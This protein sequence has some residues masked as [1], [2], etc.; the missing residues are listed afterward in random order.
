MIL[1]CIGF[2]VGFKPSDNDILEEVASL[3]ERL[4]Q[5]NDSIAFN[6]DEWKRLEDNQKDLEKGNAELRKEKEAT[7]TKIKTLLGLG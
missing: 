7:E 1:G 2:C 3:K 4:D 5:I 6:S